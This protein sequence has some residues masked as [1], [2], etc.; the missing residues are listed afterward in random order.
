MIRRALNLALV[1]VGVL[2]LAG[3]IVMRLNDVGL[4]PVLSGSM[5]PLAQPGDLAV[6]SRVPA[7]SLRVGDVIVFIPP[8]E[9]QQVMHRIATLE[10]VDGHIVITTKGDAN[11]AP[12]NWK[13]TLAGTDARRLAFMV[14]LVGW[15]PE[16]RGW[17]L[18]AAGVVLG[19]VLLRQVRRKEAS[20]LGS[21][22]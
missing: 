4:D 22:A 1:L 15:L 17:F 6:T 8:H 21:P 7:S 9:T 14:P 16:Y 12:D 11:N 19:L 3:G 5:R 18:I 10:T 20:T 2:V 13:A